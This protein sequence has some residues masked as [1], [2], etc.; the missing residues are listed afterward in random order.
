ML[1]CR[2]LMPMRNRRHFMVG[3]ICVLKKRLSGSLNT[4][5]TH[6]KVFRAGQQKEPAIYFM[7]N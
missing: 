7:P 6:P 5:P 1:M 4:P 3:S 2:I